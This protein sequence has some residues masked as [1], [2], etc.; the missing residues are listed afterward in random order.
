MF[1]LKIRD[2]FGLPAARES[3]SPFTVIGPEERSGV[4]AF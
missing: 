3:D 1:I 2:G 4:A